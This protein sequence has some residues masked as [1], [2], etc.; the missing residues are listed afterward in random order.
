[1]GARKGQFDNCTEILPTTKVFHEDTDRIFCQ[2]VCDDIKSAFVDP[3]Q[4]RL[5]L[6]I[7]LKSRQHF[8]NPLWKSNRHTIPTGFPPGFFVS[9]L[10]S[11]HCRSH[12]RLCLCCWHPVA[13]SSLVSIAAPVPQHVSSS[14]LFCF[15]QIFQVSC[16][17]GEWN[18]RI[19]EQV[20]IQM[21]LSVVSLWSLRRLASRYVAP[22]SIPDWAQVNH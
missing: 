21:S 3:S 16:V 7:V 18:N 6:V 22:E 17:F 9:V 11:C 1:M 8:R 4:Q 2:Q 20:I 14:S 10:L 12:S 5:R 13:L 15:S 19:S